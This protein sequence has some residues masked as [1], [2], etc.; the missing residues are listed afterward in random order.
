MDKAKKKK[1]PFLDIDDINKNFD[2]L[3]NEINLISSRMGDLGLEYVNKISGQFISLN[4]DLFFRLRNSIQYRLGAILLHFT[5]LLDIQMNFQERID[6]DPFNQ[7]ESIKWMILGAEQQYALFDS[8]VFHIISLFDYLGNLIDYILGG[9]SQSRLKWNGV[10]HLSYDNKSS[11]SKL[12]IKNVLQK[13]HSDF[14]N[15]LYNHRSDLIHY[16]M[17]FGDSSY[18]IDLNKGKAKLRIEAPHRFTKNFKELKK[19]AQENKISINYA[20]DWLIR[21]SIEATKEIINSI[22][23]TMEENRKVP[24]EKEIFLFKKKDS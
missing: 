11:L 6:E 1:L 14:I 15:I 24:K 21:K 16:K 20:I 10:I 13:L 4:N 23:T 3:R 19:I 8:I 12:P 2:F 9:K 17:D 5:L 22:F 7:E 18:S